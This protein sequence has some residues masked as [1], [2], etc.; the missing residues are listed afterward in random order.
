M[1][2]LK[3]IELQHDII[4][5]SFLRMNGIEAET[6]SEFL[7]IFEDQIVQITGF[8]YIHNEWERVIV[9]M[10]SR[11]ATYDEMCRMKDCFFEKDEIAIQIHPPKSEYVN[12]CEFAL[13]LWRNKRLSEKS[14]KR[15]RE[16][17]LKAYKE[18]KEIYLANAKRDFLVPG[19]EKVVAVCG[20]NRWPTWEEVCAV[21][22]R[23]W[24][25]EEAA[26][27]FN[28][29]IEEDINAEYMILLW[30]AADMLLPPK[31]FV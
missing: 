27:Q 2:N 10:H 25:P 22:Q 15:L 23:Y 17:V 4:A 7:T 26:V 3:K 14:E 31:E 30:D 19:E 1:K 28:L 16:K 20:K 9:Y 6:R 11:C 12:I 5:E 18:A 8:N 21:K 13:H 24:E 29:S